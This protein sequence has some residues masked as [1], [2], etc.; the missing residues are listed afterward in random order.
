MSAGTS[1]APGPYCEL[2]AH[3]CFSLLDGVPFPEELAEAAAARGLPALALTDHDAIYGAVPFFARAREVGVK[4]LLGAELTLADGAHLTLLAEDQGGYRNLGRLITLARAGQPKG[5]AALPWESLS[6]PAHTAG[7]VCLTGCRRG[8]VAASW[9]RGQPAQAAQALDRLVEIFGRANVYV[10][11]QRHLQ[12]ADVRLGRA[13]AALAHARGL[14]VVAT[15]NAHYLT[16]EDAS[17]HDALVSVRERAPLPRAG[18]HLRPNHEFYLRGPAAMA[19]FFA[20]FP[21]ALSN[22]LAVAER[23]N[24]ALP[25]GLQTLP[26]YPLPAGLSALDY[27]RQLCEEAL[28]GP[29]PPGPLPPLRFAAGAMARKGRGESQGRRGLLMPPFSPFAG[30]RRG[31]GMREVCLSAPAPC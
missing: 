21:E 26:A 7:L 3:S 13:L 10:E 14:P 28:M 15:G 31:R 9:L 4:P 16:P 6:L 23:C 17:L 8:P 29:N 11:V 24:V 27:L 2:H 19:A 5:Q 25:T 30:G 22:T 18:P 20:D 1:T 12:R